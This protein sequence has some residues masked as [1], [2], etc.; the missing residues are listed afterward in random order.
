MR[1]NYP[2]KYLRDAF[3]FSALLMSPPLVCSAETMDRP[4]NDLKK[5]SIEQLMEVEVDTV[6][7]ASKYEQKVTEAPSSVSIVTADDI[8]KYGHRTLAD[9][10]RSVRGFYVTYD[11]NYSYVGVRGVGRSGDY[12]N[13]ILLLV[14]G[15][16]IND[17]LYDQAPLGTEL[18]V[19]VDLIE[20]VEV[21]RGPG[22]SLYGSNAFFAIINVIT[23]RGEDIDGVEMSGDAGSFDTFQGRVTYGKSFN[24]GIEALFS[25]SYY[26][27]NGD[28]LFFKEF[29]TSANNNG[30][31][32]H[33][34][35][36]R[37]YNTLAKLS[38][39]DFTLEGV[40]SSR[41]KGI[42]TASFGADFNDRR[43]RTTDSHWLA[44]LKY[45]RS[46]GESADVTGRLFYDSYDYDG[47]Y[48]Y[49]GVVNR[50]LGRGRWWGG[51][52]QTAVKLFDRHRLIAGS[53]F[54]DNIRQDQQNFDES[55]F[56][57]KLSDRRDSRIWALYLQDE[58][59]IFN[60]LILNAGVRYDHYSTFGSTVNPRLALIYTP[61][62]G[63]V[64]KFLYG[65]AFRAP[66]VFELYYNL[67]SQNVK[68]NP[69]LGPE[70]IR[71][72][73]LIYEQY[74]GNH[75]RGTIS[76]FYNNID[77]LIVQVT[78]QAD[79]FFV[80]K[81]L[82]RAQADGVETE[83]EAKFDNGLTGRASYTFQD[84]WDSDTGQTLVNSP[85]H[86]AKLNVTIPLLHEKIFLG[87]EEQFTDRRK[88]L[89]DGNFA[90]S[91]FVTNLTLYS[92]D[93]LKNLE[94]SASLYN[95][96]DCRYGDPGGAEHIQD[97]AHPLDIIHQ[98]GRTFR[99]KLTYKF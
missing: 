92:R 21:I 20:R 36:D 71:T 83:L 28:R 93:L 67:P 52:L 79:G 69:N 5:L 43:N 22:S 46:L 65:S 11:R 84:A 75:I 2:K 1:T 6:Y 96:F 25:G 54:R 97:P 86:L 85:R 60:N 55:P 33:T 82:S 42:P 23:R 66:N 26:D 30:I 73:E 34:D 47:D 29:D 87:I 76:G 68:G 95:L 56:P 70:K 99:V 53:E 27:S 9:I 89:V 94:L 58:Y 72:Y 81:N 91:F 16:R 24:N 35:Y 63:T 7:A 14:D 48:V 62:A 31:T 17:N 12:N 41:T 13:R 78:D 39:R 32:D 50:D 44:D 19:D 57:S 3:L 37:F 59:T 4:E 15:H 10:L 45:A 74:I 61:L 38:Y 88:T 98:D 51:E 64:F 40:Y 80:F 77:N 8:K 49:N 90:K 18:P